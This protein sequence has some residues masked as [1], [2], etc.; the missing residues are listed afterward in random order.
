MNHLAQIVCL[1]RAIYE[2]SISPRYLC[3]SPC[4][5]LF[6]LFPSQLA[7]AP[8]SLDQPVI[9]TSPHSSVWYHLWLHRLLTLLIMIVLSPT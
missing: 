1:I 3:I 2:L 9:M 4:Q 7:L 8:E 5:A 6:E